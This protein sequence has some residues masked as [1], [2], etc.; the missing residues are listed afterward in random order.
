MGGSL[1][2]EWIVEPVGVGQPAT[3]SACAAANMRWAVSKAGGACV[4]YTQMSC[5]AEGR[6]WTALRVGGV[7]APKPGE[8]KPAPVLVAKKSSLV[9][10]L[11]GVVFVGVLVLWA[12]NPLGK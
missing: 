3:P 11:V 4:P 5:V 12:T 6:Q 8:A 2:I 1:V 7:C 9:P 10:V